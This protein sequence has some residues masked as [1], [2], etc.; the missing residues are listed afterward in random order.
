MAVV[1]R[2]FAPRLR[3]ARMDRSLSQKQLADMAGTHVMQI[4]RY[5]RG[6][7]LPA[8]EMALTL[9]EVLHIS[10]DV[11]L[12]GRDEGKAQTIPAISDLRLYERFLEAEKL[13]RQDREAIILL[14]DSVITH[15]SVE[16][17]IDKHRR[18]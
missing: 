6:E 4:S 11:L 16:A 15:R 17:Q 13:E 18:A 9:A 3:K 12:L 8:F 10:A 14:I 5:E 2:A 1:A 7:V